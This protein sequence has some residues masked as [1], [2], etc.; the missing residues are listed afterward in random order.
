MEKRFI[1]TN[2]KGIRV[3]LK[4]RISEA[5]GISAILFL[6]SPEQAVWKLAKPVIPELSEFSTNPFS[7]ERMAGKSGMRC[8]T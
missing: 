5:L 2:G 8:Q 1:V 7:K 3:W 4:Q 6:Q